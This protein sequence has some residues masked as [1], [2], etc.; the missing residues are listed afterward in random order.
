MQLGAVIRLDAKD[1]FRP[2]MGP[3]AVWVTGV[4][5]ALNR[6]E[7]DEWVWLEGVQ[8]MHD[9]QS[10]KS[11]QILVRASLLSPYRTDR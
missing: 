10:G 1:R 5:L 8:M 2:E 4:R 3:I 9:G 11:V 6:P 7:R